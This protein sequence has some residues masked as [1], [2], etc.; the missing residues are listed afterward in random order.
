MEGSVFRII[1]AMALAAAAAAAMTSATSAEMSVRSTE[2]LPPAGEI[3]YGVENLTDREIRTAWCVK[4][5]RD[6]PAWFSVQFEQ[7][8]RL[9]ELGWFGGYQKNSRTYRANARA[10][11]VVVHSDGRL[12][13]RFQLNDRLG[14][15]TLRLPGDPAREYRFVIETVYPGTKYDDLCVTEILVDRRTVD[16]YALSDSLARDAGSRALTEAEIEAQ[17]REI[18][19]FWRSFFD[20][21]WGPVGPEYDRPFWNAVV[22]RT[23]ARD[24]GSLRF[25]LNLR[26]HVQRQRIGSVE[27]SEGLRDL[28]I[29]Y[30]EDSPSVVADVWEDENQIERTTISSAYNMFVDPWGSDGP[31]MVRHYRATSPGF[32]R[33]IGQVCREHGAAHRG[34]PYFCGEE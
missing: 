12:L 23:S 13:G 30:F 26:H 7:P 32:D 14:L 33:F 27:L 29:P 31:E 4:R 24:E 9:A 8:T 10:K 15:Q 5:N 21:K 1:P 19:S 16:G 22:L 2:S 34:W 11:T 28:V 18:S 3:R 6:R 25:L 20:D 17:Y